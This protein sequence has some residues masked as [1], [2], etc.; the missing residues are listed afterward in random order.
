MEMTVKEAMQLLWDSNHMGWREFE[1]K[2]PEFDE[3]Y[4]KI[5]SENDRYS[6]NSNFVI[7]DY[8][9]LPAMEKEGFDS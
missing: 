1:E 4:E 5:T 7:T 8:I 2:Y 6:G 9:L 3:F